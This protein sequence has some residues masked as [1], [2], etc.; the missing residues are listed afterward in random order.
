[1]VFLLIQIPGHKDFFFVAHTAPRSSSSIAEK[2][3]FLVFEI[4]E[5]DMIV[6]RD[7]S[8]HRSSLTPSPLFKRRSFTFI[9]F[10][11][12]NDLFQGNLEIKIFLIEIHFNDTKTFCSGTGLMGKE[13]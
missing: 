7:A 2:V 5:E 6:I 13:G 1:M 8:S 3:I 12:Q 9:F 10:S 4:I 11:C